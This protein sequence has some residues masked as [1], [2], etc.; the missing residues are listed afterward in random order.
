MRGYFA[1]VLSGTLLVT[2]LG[3]ASMAPSEFIL[4]EKEYLEQGGI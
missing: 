4:K 3:L 1:R 2:F